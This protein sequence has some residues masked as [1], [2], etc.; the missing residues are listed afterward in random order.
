[1][2]ELLSYLQSEGFKVYIVT[3]GDEDF[4]R[5]FSE[6]V[7]SIPP[8]QV[9]GSAFRLQFIENNRSVSVVKLPQLLVIDDG[10]EKAKEIQQNIGKR[11]IFAYG[12][13]DGDIPMLQFTTSDNSHGMGLLNHHDDPVREF[14]YDR[15]SA[16]GRLDR[17]L[18]MAGEWDWQIVSMKDDWK[19]IF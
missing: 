10:Q 11:P 12:N 6:E 17:G 8:E 13:S 18:D 19:E 2:L 14:A 3:G 9:I 1:M 5:T 16:I 7:Y 4:V 15:Q